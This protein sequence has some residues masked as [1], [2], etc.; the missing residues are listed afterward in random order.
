MTGTALCDSGCGLSGFR[1]SFQASKVAANLGCIL[2]AQ[3][4]VLLQRLVNNSLQLRGNGAIQPHRSNGSY[5][6]QRAE[7]SSRSVTFERHYSC[8]HF[9][10]HNAKGEQVRARVEFLSGGL[11][12]RH[13]S[14]RSQNGVRPGDLGS[15]RHGRARRC[16]LRRL[17]FRQPEI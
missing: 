13:V 4:S 5:V 3:L 10:K 6:Q 7:H 8:R 12:R 1:V 16:F 11:F 15:P 14:N 9:V 17:K 2:I